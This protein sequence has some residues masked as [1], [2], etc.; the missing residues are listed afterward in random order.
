MSAHE[1]SIAWVSSAYA[2]TVP[3]QNMHEY[4]IDITYHT[5]NAT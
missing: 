2:R 1:G 4:T 5:I 3:W